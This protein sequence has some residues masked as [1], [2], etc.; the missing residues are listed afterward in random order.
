MARGIKYHHHLCVRTLQS[1]Q[2][3]QHQHALLVIPAHGSKTGR[4]VLRT[5][6]LHIVFLRNAVTSWHDVVVF[7]TGST[8]KA[9]SWVAKW[10]AICATLESLVVHLSKSVL[11]LL[12][13]KQK[14]QCPEV[15]SDAD[16]LFDK[17]VIVVSQDERT[18]FDQ[19]CILRHFLHFIRIT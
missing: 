17:L 13:P 5:G 12:S 18:V 3:Q 6:M 16:Q 14:S 9:N 8:V 15:R 1:V 11:S 7:F 2:E 10:H 4:F 19:S